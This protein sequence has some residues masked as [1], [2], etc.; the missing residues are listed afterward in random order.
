MMKPVLICLTAILILSAGCHTNDPV[1]VP[2][3]GSPPTLTGIW[4]GGTSHVF[5]LYIEVKQ[6]R[7]KVSGNGDLTNLATNNVIN[8]DVGGSCTYP[9]VSMTFV[10]EDYTPF[11]FSGTFVNPSA[12]SGELNGSGFDHF[13]VTL[14]KQ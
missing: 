3:F 13:P 11:T 6:V 9:T 4:K 12:I 5:E 2:P 7:A 10:M 1:S 8:I 14:N